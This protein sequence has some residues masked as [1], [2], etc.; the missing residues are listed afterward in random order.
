MYIAVDF[1]STCVTDN[2][3]DVGEDIGAAPVLKELAQQNHSIILWTMRSGRNLDLAV[4]WFKK[5]DIP[6]HGINENPDQ[7]TWTT[8]PKA[9]A[10]ILIDDVA[11]GCP[12]IENPNGPNYVDWHKVRHHLT[13]LGAL[14]PK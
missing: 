9:Y 7:K 5:N 2:Y 13:L 6:L 3:P 8:S 14:P 12:L 1:D 11:L 10:H 4:N